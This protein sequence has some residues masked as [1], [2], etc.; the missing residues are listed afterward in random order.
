MRPARLQSLITFIRLFKEQNPAAVKEDVQAAIEAQF[1]VVK[2]RS[3]YL[4]ED[5]ALRVSESNVGSFSNVVLSLST[6][7]KYDHVPV[8]VVVVRPDG[9]GFLLANSTFL[10][11]VSHSSHR[12]AVDNVKGSFLGHDILR[13]FDGIANRPENIEA[14]FSLHQDVTWE[15]NLIRLVESTT[16]IAPTGR[17]FEPTEEQVTCVMAAPDLAS[18]TLS[19][20]AYGEIETRLTRS[21]EARAAEILQA[22]RIENVNLRGNTIER[23]ITEAGNLHGLSDLHFELGGGLELIV[24]VKTKLLHLASSPK[25]YNIDRALRFLA[26]GGGLFSLLLVGIDT[27]S[28]FVR[29]RLVSIFDRVVV[30]ATRIQFHWA[31]RASRGVTQ[32]TGDVA[33]CFQDDFRPEIAIEESRVLLKSFLDLTA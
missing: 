4:L 7:Q 28:G 8:V 22:A 2:Q 3:V 14:L 12:L 11:R 16:A 30:S 31:G 10:K 27:R 15:E 23:I 1:A 29:P 13:E 24:D 26:S 9:V 5:G 33:R 21:V 19:S 25:L 32:L 6:L 20:T 17:R 18:R